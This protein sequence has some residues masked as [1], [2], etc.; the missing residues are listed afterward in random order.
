MYP[1]RKWLPPIYTNDIITCRNIACGV[2]NNI[3][4][5]GELNHY[6]FYSDEELIGVAFSKKYEIGW[7]FRLKYNNKLLFFSCF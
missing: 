7:R 2:Y 3:K 1:K 4:I 6:R 5:Y